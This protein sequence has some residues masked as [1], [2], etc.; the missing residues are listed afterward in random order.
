MDGAEKL[1]PKNKEESCYRRV[2]LDKTIFMVS[3]PMY[4]K[5]KKDKICLVV[6]Y[7]MVVTITLKM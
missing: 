4:V 7:F 5:R 2:K 6:N 1:R 3:K